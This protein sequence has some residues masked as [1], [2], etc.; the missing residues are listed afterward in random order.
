MKV[1]HIISNLQSGGAEAM[2][3]KVARVSAKHGIE[4]SVI[5]MIEGGAVAD[6]LKAAGIP[7]RFLGAGRSFGAL[8]RIGALRR[9]VRKIKPDLVQGWMYHGNIAASAAANA[10]E[11][12]IPVLWNV[13]QSLL[14]L[15]HE[16]LVTN[17]TIFL[18]TALRHTPEMII[19]N[20][21]RAA[22]DHERRGYPRKRRVIIPNGFN[23]DLYRPDPDCRPSLIQ[24]LGLPAEAEIVGRVANFRSAKDYPNLMVAF[25]AIAKADPRAH[26]V[27][28]GRDLK[29]NPQLER[30]IQALPMPEK[31]HV[32]GERT[33]V[34]R[35][36]PAFDLMLSNSTSEAFPNV[37]GEAMACGVPSITTDAGDC[38]DVLGDPAR[39]IEPGN[40]ALLAQKALGILAL[41]RTQRA[42][43]G[44]ADRA[45]VV[46]RY[47]IEKIATDYAAL[48]RREGGMD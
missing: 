35:I 22:E 1:L 37:L 14:G 32:L 16:T 29:D 24:E 19:Y 12:P 10:C 28:I 38:K 23:T 46:E 30:M 26:L 20:S 21:V 4:H 13:R 3:S 11:R 25:A 39:V 47:S 42:A 40:P 18:G 33:D 41:D 27:L 44:A 45:R 5:S 48:W 15:R 36:M 43:I 31:V 17:A 34:P 9:A 8:L 7:V 2:L 6:E